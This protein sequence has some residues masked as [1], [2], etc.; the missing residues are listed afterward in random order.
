MSSIPRSTIEE[1]AKDSALTGNV[2]L[3]VEGNTDRLFV[4]RWLLLSNNLE[5]VVVLTADRI[6]VDNGE[7][8]RMGLSDGNRSRVL[9][10]AR[11]SHEAD[12]AIGCI[13]DRDTGVGVD[14]YQYDNL[15]WTDY[16]ALESYALQSQVLDHANDLMFHRRLPSGVDLV[17]QI[18]PAL[19]S[20][21]HLRR[22]I[23]NLRKPNYGAGLKGRSL[24]EFDVEKAT[25]HKLNAEVDVCCEALD[26][27]PRHY[28]Y[29]H[30]IGNLIMAAFAND[31]KNRLGFAK[32][33]AVESALRGAVFDFGR[34]SEEQMFVNLAK[35]LKCRVG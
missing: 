18:K 4:E 9:F 11:I 2:A 7:V 3:V 26:G 29:G 27:D 15:F 17:D 34:I 5:R 32:T 24:P 31:L 28:A 25:G 35:W 12:L 6:E 10:L 33:E 14:E 23:P 16:P 20:L 22:S 19:H 1:I 13:A 30:D 21:F 8:M